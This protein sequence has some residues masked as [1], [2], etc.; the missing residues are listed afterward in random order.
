MI[1]DIDTP[2][3]TSLTVNGRLTFWYNETDPKNLTIHTMI[4]YVRQG[5]LLIGNE[6]HPYVGNA[7]IILYGEPEDET[8]AYSYTVETGNKVLAIVGTAKFYGQARDRVSRLRATV[9]K[10]DLVATVSGGLDWVA[11]D[12]LAILP[13]AI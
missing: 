8:L 12:K 13:T 10:N 6:T 11:G 9:S 1:L 5:E 3:L 4:L 7:T 2:F